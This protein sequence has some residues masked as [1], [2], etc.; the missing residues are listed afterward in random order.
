MNDY[1]RLRT[2]MTSDA[3]RLG[4]YGWVRDYLAGVVAGDVDADAVRHP[5]GF[6]CFPAWRDGVL[7]IC[8]HVW[9]DGARA[10]PTTSPIH[11][12]SWDLLSL[13]LYGAVANEIIEVSGPP[14]TPTH[15]IFEIH[16]DSDGDLVRATPGAV[17]YRVRSRQVFGRGEIYTLPRGVFHVSDVRGPAATVVLGEYRPGCPDRSLGTLTTEDHW[18]HRISCATRE[19]VHAAQLVLDRM[20]DQAA[21]RDLEER[22]DRATS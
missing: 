12:H 13:V 4:V 9:V 1:A 2:L 14:T 17:G 3:T 11:A 10:C 22:C 8:V 21:S 15:R 16:S 6:L 19:S 5:L 7:G 20:A 18:V